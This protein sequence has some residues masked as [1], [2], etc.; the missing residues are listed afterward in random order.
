MVEV[1]CQPASRGDDDAVLARGDV[2]DGQG[3]VGVGRQGAVRTGAVGAGGAAAG[4]GERVAARGIGGPERVVEDV[5]HHGATADAIPAGWLLEHDVELGEVGGFRETRVGRATRGRPLRRP[6]DS[7]LLRQIRGAVERVAVVEEIDRDLGRGYRVLLHRH[8][9]AGAASRHGHR[10]T[11]HG[12][13]GVSENRDVVAA[14]GHVD[15]RR[16]AA[17][18]AGYALTGALGDGVEA[19]VEVQPELIG[20][21]RRIQGIHRIGGVLLHQVAETADTRAVVVDDVDGDLFRLGVERRQ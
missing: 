4:A 12:I 9:H 1:C 18:G 21:R 16:A 11:A 19:L 3:A 2:L 13:P 6:L 15:D 14:G 7:K 8:V 17:R 5:A 20:Q 10:R